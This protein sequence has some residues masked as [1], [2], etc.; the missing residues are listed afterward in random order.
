MQIIDLLPHLRGDYIPDLPCVFPGHRNATHDAVGIAAVQQQEAHHLFRRGIGIGR[1]KAVAIPRHLHQGQPWLGAARRTVQRHRFAHFQKTRDVFGAF[2][3][4]IDPVERIGDA[5]QHGTA[6]FGCGA[7][8]RWSSTIQVSLQPPPWDEFTTSE[9]RLRATRVSP[10]GLT[11][12]LAPRS[13]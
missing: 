6:S 10:P 11:Q 5:T 2:Q 3:I 13:T 4:A 8:I 9:P 1:I 12:L 7:A